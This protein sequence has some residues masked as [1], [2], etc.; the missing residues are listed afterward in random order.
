MVTNS[1]IDVGSLEAAEMAKLIDN[2]YRDHVFAYSNLMSLLAE[3]LNINFHK[4][5]DAVNFG[6][7]RNMIPKPSPG[8]GGPCLSK[9]PYILKTVMEKFA[10]NADLLAVTRRIN[11][12]GPLH[13][14]E[15]LERLLRRVGKSLDTAGKICIIGLAFKGE[16][17][18]SDMRDSTSLRFLDLLPNKKVVYA[19]DPIVPKSN[20]ESLGISSASLQEAF[21]DADAAVILNNHKSYCKW[22][23]DKLLDSMNKPAVFIDTWHNYEPLTFKRQKGILY[24]G[25]GND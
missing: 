15:K 5:A 9:D 10:I 14:K 8:V 23:I 20:I 25:L 6:Y 4:L 22:K 24:G 1:V 12:Y 11:E 7:K 13:V 18:T 16:P 2:T 3:R 17:E 19:Y 21:K